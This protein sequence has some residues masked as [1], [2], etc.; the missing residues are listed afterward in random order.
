[1]RMQYM[2]VELSHPRVEAYLQNAR[3]YE[4]A[5]IQKFYLLPDLIS[6]LVEQWKLECHTFHF[7]CKEC[8]VTLED[9]THHLGLPINGLV[10]TKTTYLNVLLFQDIYEV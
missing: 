10:V 4:V 5:R 3:L 9:V 7:P 1:M 6:A 2:N 8:T